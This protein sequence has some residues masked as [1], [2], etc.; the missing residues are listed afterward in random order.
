M[1]LTTQ[2]RRFLLVVALTV[3]PF[4]ACMNCGPAPVPLTV[5]PAT[6]P[7]GALTVPYSVQFTVAEGVEASFGL[8]SGDLPNGLTLTAEGLLSGTPLTAS[9]SRFTVRASGPMMRTGETAYELT[10]SPFAITVAPTRLPDAIRGSGYTAQ[11]SA[12]GGSP[13]YRYA[14]TSGSL[15]AGLAMTMSGQVSGVPSASGAFTITVRGTDSFNRTGDSMIQLTVVEP[16]VTLTPTTLPP[17][18]IGR[19]YLQTLVGSGGTEPYNFT[20]TS[21]A[22]PD[23]L[24][25]SPGG[26]LSGRPTTAGVSNFTVQVVDNDMNSASIPL[27]IDVVAPA[28]LISPASFPPV[29]V[30]TPFDQPLSATGGT[31]PY[32]YRISSGTLP[33]GLALDGGLLGGTPTAVITTGIDITAS[34]SMG[35]MGTRS[36]TIQIV[37]AVITL[38]PTMLPDASV[39]VPYSEQLSADG[40]TGPYLFTLTGALPAGLSLSASGLI[41]GTPTTVMTSNFTVTAADIYSSTGQQQYVLV[42]Q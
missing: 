30:G 5:E 32:T 34:D 7:N 24:V 41:S 40:G 4:S 36:F 22:V 17:G 2:R 8:A 39:G 11:L 29:T 12:A 28:V 18:T 21:G 37:G 25:L 1:S 19:N 35:A 27:S 6:I 15:P 26:E 10:I 13:P 16:A 20:I 31:A 3:A 23:G 38:T 42:V 9:T 14:I 33:P